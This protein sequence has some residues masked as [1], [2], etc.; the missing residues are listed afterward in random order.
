MQRKDLIRAI[1]SYHEAGHV[2]V[3]KLIGQSTVS[4]SLSS[5]A[6]GLT[7]V[8]RAKQDKFISLMYCMSTAVAGCLAETYLL[9]EKPDFFTDFETVLKNH[10]GA[11]KDLRIISN[12][13]NAMENLLETALSDGTIQFPSWF[14][15][16][17]EKYGAKRMAAAQTTLAI[18]DATKIINENK[19]ALCRL[20]RHI[21]VNTQMSNEEATNII[22]YYANTACSSL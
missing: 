9:K 2:L 1:V 18:K 10:S 14:L 13:Q 21:F 19:S 11:Q 22:N 8:L 15:D 3:A 4:V 7:S 12:C 17:I 16:N 5:D 6:A 20:A